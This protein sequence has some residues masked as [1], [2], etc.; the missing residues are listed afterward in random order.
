M[1]PARCISARLPPAA[2]T[3]NQMLNNMNLK[4]DPKGLEDRRGLLRALDSL[5]R[6]IDRSGVMNGITN[7]QVVRPAGAGGWRMRNH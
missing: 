3:G 7:G 2:S 4:I 1:T 5:E 6:G